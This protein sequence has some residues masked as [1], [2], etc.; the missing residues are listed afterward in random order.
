MIFFQEARLQG[1][2]AALLPSCIYVAEI[3]TI[4]TKWLFFVA[5]MN[6]SA[7]KSTY[8]SCLRMNCDFKKQYYQG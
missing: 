5:L 2:I 6:L 7:A 8:R 4:D 3:N 1:D